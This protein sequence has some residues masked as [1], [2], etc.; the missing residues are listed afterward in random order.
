[1]ALFAPREG[2]HFS[3]YRHVCPAEC[4]RDVEKIQSLRQRGRLAPAL[5]RENET[6]AVMRIL[7]KQGKN[8]VCLVGEAGVGK[9]AVVEQLAIATFLDY[10]LARFD[11]LTAE[12]QRAIDLL[13]E[14]RTA[15]ISAAVTGKIDVRELVE[16]EAA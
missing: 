5:F 1:M 10:E 16:T 11:A 6:A 4:T 2:T 9:T 3:K 7:S 13:Q 8:A 14:R 15:L 12:A